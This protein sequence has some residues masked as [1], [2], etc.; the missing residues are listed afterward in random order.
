MFLSLLNIA[1]TGFLDYRP[2][3]ESKFF[4]RSYAAD[5]SCQQMSMVSKW[6]LLQNKLKIIIKDDM[7]LC[8]FLFVT[9]TKTININKYYKN[10]KKKNLKISNRPMHSRGGG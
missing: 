6:F 3:G 7:N 4:I 2:T 1:T 5:E 8:P 9:A 10:I